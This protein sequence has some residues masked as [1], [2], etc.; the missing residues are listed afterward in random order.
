MAR[1]NDQNIFKFKRPKKNVV[2]GDAINIKSQPRRGISY[3]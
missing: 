3:R 1:D 2:F